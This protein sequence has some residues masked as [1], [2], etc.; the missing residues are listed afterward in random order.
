MTL[1]G[2]TLQQYDGTERRVEALRRAVNS[3]KAATTMSVFNPQTGSEEGW[4]A[5]YSRLED[6]LRAHSCISKLHQSQITLEILQAAAAKHAKDPQQDPIRITMAEAYNRLD[7]W[8]ERILDEQDVPVTR[9]ANHGRVLMHMIDA[10]ERWP[11]VFLS[12]EVPEE[13][14]YAVHQ[15]SI[16][17]GPDFNISTMLARPLDVKPVAELLEQGWQKIGRLG[18]G[19]IMG[20]VFVSC[21]LFVFYLKR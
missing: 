19:I 14:V 16:Q 12:D 13:F 10:P 2:G 3:A 5:A 17:S 15:T 4:K 6:Y 7:Q 18:V 21:A 8:F 20:S 11:D 9:I 1:D